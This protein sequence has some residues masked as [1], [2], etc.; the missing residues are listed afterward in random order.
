MRRT[1]VSVTASLALALGAGGVAAATASAA[2][3]D[4]LLSNTSLEI[5]DGTGAAP[6]W[7]A[8]STWGTNTTKF[9]WSAD[10][11]TGSH[12]ARVD[13]SKYT[14]GD[15]KWVP[16]V[17][18]VKGNTYYSFSDWYKSDRSSA[19]SVY[20][21]LST[22]KDTDG[23]GLPDGHWANLFSGIAP[24]SDWTQYKT[25]FTMPK[26]A[27]SAQFVHFIAGNG[28]LETDDYSL[29]EQDSPAGFSK[30]MISLTFDDGSQGD[31]DNA[32][33]LLNAKGYK[34]TQY[35][36]TAGLV[37][38]PHD[39]FLMTKDEIQTLAA[40]GN[41]IG[42]HSVTHPML[43]TVSDTQL[44]SELV[45]SKNVLEAIPGVGTVHNFAY[46]YGDYDA[47]VIQAEKDAG[48]RSGRSVEEGYNSRLDLEPY[49]IRVQNMTPETTEAE[50]ESWVDY[51]KQ[52]NYWLV[53]VYHEVQ[54]DATPRCSIPAKDSDP[55]PCVGDYDTTVSKFQTQLNYIDSSGL[56]PDVMTVQQALDA[57]DAEMRPVAGAVKISPTN[58]TPGTTLTAAP[59]GFT[60]PDNDALTYQYQWMVNGTPVS[61]ATGAT[62]TG[63]NAGDVIS[64]DVTAK[65][66]GGRTS[67]G[68]SDTVTIAAPPSSNP[69]PV[70]TP[71]PTTPSHPASVDR[72]APKIAVSSPR[73][74]TYHAGRLLKIK[75]SF[76]DASGRV[77]FEATLRRGGGKAH[78]VK[79]GAK[80]R[81][82]RTGRYTLR[83]TAK[84]RFGNTAVKTVH[85]RVVR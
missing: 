13:V 52:H 35:I 21:V 77:Q 19:V 72:K 54:K 17:V 25:G 65:D 46:P 57:T 39:S 45:D 53:I 55:D 34:S 38:T 9:T 67:A 18:P 3:G 81:L 11:H 68:V 64:V 76:S 10:A 16:D 12:S 14:D 44:K 24:A 56:G 62:F 82:S 7:W 80:V 50:F 59:T 29:T 79:Q 20:Y 5:A 84:D 4:Q 26:D 83:V 66:P 15:S 61:G 30:P 71:V 51:A 63:G 70:V 78:S 47:R 73:A 33:P 85:F 6:T 48:Y 27:V 1:V 42:G 28:Y 23:D 22:D 60:D 43:T 74:R 58:P 8:P 37:S 69:G 32:R 36:P 40:E 41:E 31:W 2:T 49:D 75:L